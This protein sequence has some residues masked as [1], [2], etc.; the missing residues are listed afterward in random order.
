MHTVVRVINDDGR[1][2]FVHVFRDVRISTTI[3]AKM[4]LGFLSLNI[5]VEPA[6]ELQASDWE[7]WIAF[8]KWWDGVRSASK[9][10]EK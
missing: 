7:A 1:N 8:V 10:E 5:T 3:M 6:S 2:L 9:G 4:P